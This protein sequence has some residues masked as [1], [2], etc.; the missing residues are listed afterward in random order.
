MT[1]QKDRIVADL[2]IKE[3]DNEQLRKENEVLK[4]NLNISI[5]ELIYL[6]ILL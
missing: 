2:L 5:K 4:K 3:Y 6:C 1:K